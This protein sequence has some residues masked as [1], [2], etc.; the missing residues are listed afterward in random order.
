[1]VLR[2]FSSVPK[3]S[4]RLTMQQ[5]EAHNARVRA[6][7]KRTP[8]ELVNEPVDRESKLHDQIIAWCKTQW[9]NWMVVHSRTDRA[10]TTAV[11]TPDFILFGP[12][13]KAF[14]VECKKAG[15]K[16]SKEQTI[17]IH[18]MNMLGWVVSIVHNMTEF[19]EAVK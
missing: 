2:I 12:Y 11:G 9:P 16:L 1:M 18:Q 8:V 7:N 6:S 19:S 5:V 15:G 13:P 14:I 4:E 3:M 17:W 10:S